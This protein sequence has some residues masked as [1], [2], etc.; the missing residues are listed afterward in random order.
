MDSVFEGLVDLMEELMVSKF[1]D[2]G[3]QI[4]VVVVVGVGVVE[5]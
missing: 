4:Q 3:D 5:I 1:L 2:R